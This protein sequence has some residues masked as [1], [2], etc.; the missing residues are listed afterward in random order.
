MN[1]HASHSPDAVDSLETSTGERAAALVDQLLAFSRRQDLEPRPVDLNE[2][3]RSMVS[4]LKPLVGEGPSLTTDLGEDVPTIEVDPTGIG[5]ATIVTRGAKVPSNLS[6][7]VP[8]SLARGRYA[9][10]EFSDDGMGMDPD[11]VERVFEPF[12][13]TKPF[14]EGSG[15]GLATVYGIVEQTAGAIQVESELDRGTTFRIWLP[16]RTQPA[17]HARREPGLA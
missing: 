9:V 15:T 13:S 7:G 11:T 1:L 4:M 16:A 2:L 6:A 3:V 10:L 8:E 5:R 12:F 14:G 17:S